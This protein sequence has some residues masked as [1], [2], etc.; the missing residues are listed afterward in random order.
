MTARNNSLAD[1]LIEHRDDP[2]PFLD[3]RLPL[4]KLLDMPYCGALTKKLEDVAGEWETMKAT[5]RAADRLPAQPG[6]YM[7][8]WRPP[9]LFRAPRKPD[10]FAYILYVGKAGAEQSDA[11]IKS[12]Y[13]EYARYLEGDPELLWEEPLVR[14]RRNLFSRYLMLEPLELW[15]SVIPDRQEVSRLER[16]LVHMLNPPLNDQ[17]TPRRG[18]FKTTEPAFRQPGS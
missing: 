11:T 13:R 1:A 3:L 17:L 18:R 9:L 8:V 12:R 10:S 16:Q 15:Y 2:T 7:F 6:L 14:D 5:Q 4:L